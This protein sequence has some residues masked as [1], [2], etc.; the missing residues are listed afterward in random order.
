M[1][2]K[3]SP[4]WNKEPRNKHLLDYL[5][6]TGDDPNETDLRETREGV[7]QKRAKMPSKVHRDDSR[8]YG[9]RRLNIPNMTGGPFSENQYSEYNKDNT[10]FTHF[11]QSADKKV[12]AGIKHLG[13]NRYGVD[14]YGVSADSREQGVGQGGFD[15]MRR[16]L[17][18]M[19]GGPVELTGIGQPNPGAEGFWDK[20][21][22]NN[23]IQN[24]VIVKQQCPTP[25]KKGFPTQQEA[26]DEAWHIGQGLGVYQC[27]CGQFHF[28]SGVNKMV[29]VKE[30]KSPAAIEHKRKYETEYESSPKRKKYRRELEGE[31]RK[32]GVDGKGGGDMSHTK[33]GKIVVEDPHTNRARSHPS[34]GSTLKMVKIIKTE[35]APPSEQGDNPPA[36]TSFD[37]KTGKV[38]RSVVHGQPNMNPQEATRQ[39]I[40]E[41]MH[42]ATLPEVGIENM[43][44]TEFPAMLG[45]EL[46]LQRLAQE[47]NPH[48]KRDPHTLESIDPITQALYRTGK[49][50]DVPKE[51]Q[52]E[53]IRNYAKRKN[54][55]TLKMVIVKAP[56]YDTVTGKQVAG[57][58]TPA[59]KD[60]P[61]FDF[62]YD[63][64][65]H[66]TVQPNKRFLYQSPNQK[67]RAIV[68]SNTKNETATIPIF[69][70]H[71]KERGKGHGRQAL[72][73]L[74]TEVR[75][76][77]PN[78]KDIEPTGVTAEAE[79]FWDPQD[80]DGER[81]KETIRSRSTNT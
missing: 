81:T 61:N 56:L 40:H 50:I 23:I 8:D 58:P 10:N 35:F 73:N 77:H 55:R 74:N 26:E 57:V 52:D 5:R 4:I 45:E 27:P 6:S 25:T 7:R 79:P 78:V 36:S 76:I 39:V 64:S 62:E 11:Y 1:K 41:D 21:N 49:H 2:L 38:G 14:H 51:Q 34:V 63:Y 24:M 43:G 47:G 3:K 16:E 70:T 22:Q 32:R 46:Y 59:P 71:H 68:E 28:T 30:A 29:V 54:P 37:P 19:H 53:Y 75:S 18:A 42:R 13:D 65:N 33:T 72:R 17:E 48:R 15:E 9:L 66:G 60:D 67:V 44:H 12:R 80:G 69:A 20:M 31:R